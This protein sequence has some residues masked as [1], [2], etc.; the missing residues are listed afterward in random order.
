MVAWSKNMKIE[1]DYKAK[2]KIWATELDVVTLPKAIG[3][4]EFSCRRFSS[5][6]DMNI[7]KK[8]MLD[9]IARNGGLRWTK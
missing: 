9:E 1:N 3:F 6:E 4:P 8:S 7:W 2:L 5:G